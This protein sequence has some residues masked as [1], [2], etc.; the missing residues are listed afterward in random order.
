MYLFF[1]LVFSFKFIGVFSY[2][3]VKLESDKD[4]YS[5]NSTVYIN[6]T[7][8]PPGRYNVYLAL[9][10]D[11]D[12]GRIRVETDDSGYFYY[13]WIPL[14]RK[15]Y[16]SFAEVIDQSGYV[17]RSNIVEIDVIGGP[18][19]HWLEVGKYVHYIHNMIY[20][21]SNM[22]HRPGYPALGYL[23]YSFGYFGHEVTRGEFRHI[24]LVRINE[25]YGI[26]NIGKV[27]AI[28]YVNLTNRDVLDLS[29]LTVRGKTW[30]WVDSNHKIGDNI[31]INNDLFIFEDV[32]VLSI[33]GESRKCWVLT[34]SRQHDQKLWYEQ[35]MGLLIKAENWVLETRDKSYFIDFYLYDS[36][37][38]FS[39]DYEEN[40][41]EAFSSDFNDT[42]LL[43][44]LNKL[45]DE[46][47]STQK[48]LEEMNESYISL[49]NSYNQLVKQES[50]ESSIFQ[51]P[52]FS[53]LSL[54][55]A[56]FTIYY[57]YSNKFEIS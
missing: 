5:L 4:V 51:V 37:I 6:G 24:D 46:L 27:G 12:G 54:L 42:N 47:N 18:G 20:E 26:D 57:L 45:E 31:T 19:P 56:Y 3:L 35:E 34:N 33:F 15:A 2:P 13:E 7:V 43:N 44:R 10:G 29:K 17:V 36:N 28:H 30:L 11:R 55:F 39:V 25:R 48:E 32:E 41:K 40:I 38:E 50:S 49:N 9:I 21:G 14:G 53:L 8:S 16:R 22:A 23:E 1:V 52:S